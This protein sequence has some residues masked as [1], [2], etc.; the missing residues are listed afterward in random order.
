MHSNARVSRYFLSFV[1]ILIYASFLALILWFFSWLGLSV[2]NYFFSKSLPELYISGIESDGFYAG[3]VLCSVKSKDRYKVGDISIWLD[4]K[5]LVPKCK[6]NKKEFDSPFTI[7]TKIL[8]NGK[9]VLLI[10]AQNKTYAKLKNS[11]EMAFNVDN[12]PLQG[13]FVKSDTEFKVFQGRTLHLQFQLNKEIESAYASA[14][15]NIYQCF[16]E[17][18]DSL[19][20]ECL[21]PIDCEQQPNEYPIS[22]NVT[23]KVGNVIT[24]DNKFQVV[25]YP[26]KRQNLNLDPVKIKEENDSGLSE[27]QLELE[28]E[29]LTKNSPLKK[30]WNG[31]FVTPTEIRSAQQITTQFGVIRTTQERGLRSHKALDIYN[32][33]KSVI[34]APQDGIIV[35]KNR[36]AHAGNTVVIDHGYGVLTLLFHLDNFADIQVGDKIK[37]GNPVGTLGKTGYATGYH[38]HWEM[39]VNNVAVDPM[40]WTKHDF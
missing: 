23:D 3:D 35:L 4:G 37:R 15:S 29:E 12:I 14:L 26:F 25:M 28:I 36:Y 27:R 16:S 33:P 1:K 5:M 8:N 32:T 6:I 19:I 30:L 18:K 21:I 34:W 40:E 10:E 7:P 2:Y 13:A 11:Q 38:L 24:L 39:R 22:I 9:H 31:I 20:Y 17:A